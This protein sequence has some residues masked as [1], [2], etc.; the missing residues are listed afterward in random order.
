M[1]ILDDWGITI[2]DLNIVLSERPAIRGILVGFL[3][4]YKLQHNIFNDARI[5]KLTRYPDHDR[6][7]PAD[8][9][10]T[11]HGREYTIEVKSLQSN[12]VRRSNGH[13][14]GSAQVDA[15]DKRP[16]ELPNGEMVE[17]TCLVAGKFDILAVNLYEFRQKW[18][19]A[20]IANANLPRSAYRKYTAEQRNHLLK[21][22]VT[23]NWP[24]E[25]PFYSDPFEL[26]GI[27]EKQRG[28]K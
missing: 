5:H 3:A 7:R 1:G 21:T 12:S 28:R 22:I 6:S 2:D 8:F 10:F 18:E 24:L 26:L 27:L 13:Y 11:F 15:S 4:E 14:R 19:Y 20:F 9:S 17:T 23:I 16:V 25:P